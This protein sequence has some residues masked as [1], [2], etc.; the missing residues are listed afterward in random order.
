MQLPDVNGFEERRVTVSA[1]H[2]Q[3]VARCLVSWLL[4]QL[5]VGVTNVQGTLGDR[6]VQTMYLDAFRQQ[7]AYLLDY[8]AVDDA[9][10]Y[11]WKT[12]VPDER[13]PASPTRR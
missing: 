3:E 11:F 6:L 5:P 8:A 10:E 13:M 9:A 1:L 7:A 12:Y 4:S 2:W